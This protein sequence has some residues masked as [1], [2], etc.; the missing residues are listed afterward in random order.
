[1]QVYDNKIADHFKLKM[2]SENIKRDVV[3]YDGQIY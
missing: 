1:L 3:Q 2:V